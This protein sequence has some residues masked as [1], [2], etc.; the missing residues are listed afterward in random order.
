M[1]V[2][3]VEDDPIIRGVL[4][5]YF[6]IKG[7]NASE[8]VDGRA[9]LEL[10]GQVQRPDLIITDIMMPRMNG[11]ALID[12]IKLNPR[13]QKI[14]IIII[15]AGKIDQDKYTESGASEIFQKPLVLNLLLRKAEE[16]VSRINLESQK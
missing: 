5:Q 7:H 11:Y 10:L 1:E 16:L 2:L 3:V 8:A 13:L 14:P 12:A 15:T 9:A 6:T 4:K